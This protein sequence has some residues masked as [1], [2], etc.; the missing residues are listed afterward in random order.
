MA[1]N[2]AEVLGTLLCSHLSFYNTWDSQELGEEGP[3]L[4]WGKTCSEFF[5]RLNE[6][7]VNTFL[8]LFCFC[9]ALQDLC[10]PDFSCLKSGQILR[11]ET[12]QHILEMSVPVFGFP[13]L[14]VLVKGIATLHCFSWV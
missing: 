11:L 4:G 9:T 6:V 12:K 8:N 13:H 14:N 1:L 10:H 5:L 7:Q 2:Q 3:R